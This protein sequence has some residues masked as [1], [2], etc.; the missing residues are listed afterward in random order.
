MGIAAVRRSLHHEPFYGSGGGLARL[1]RAKLRLADKKLRGAR[2]GY[3]AFRRLPDGH[4]IP[5]N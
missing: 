1:D 3:L 4:P 5:V 2:S